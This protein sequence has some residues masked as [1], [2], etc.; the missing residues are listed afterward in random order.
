MKYVGGQSEHLKYGGGHPKH[1]KYVG[2]HPKHLEHGG[3]HPG[4]LEYGGGQ[5][6]Y[7]EYAECSRDTEE[8]QQN[9]MFSIE[10]DNISSSNLFRSWFLGYRCKS[11][12]FLF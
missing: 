11:G 8:H 6:E 9:T 3:G 4:H 5:P 7:L 10:N 2:G 1:L 12:I